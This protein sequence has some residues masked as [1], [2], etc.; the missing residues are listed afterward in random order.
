MK[1]VSVLVTSD[2]GVKAVLQK[3]EPYVIALNTN[4]WLRSWRSRRRIQ[5]KEVEGLVAARAN[6]V[7]QQI[8]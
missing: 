6:E 2:L 7:N 8:S 3:L 4:T 1:A 5:R